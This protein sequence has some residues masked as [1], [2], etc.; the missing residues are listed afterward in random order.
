MDVRLRDRIDSCIDLSRSV[1]VLLDMRE[2]NLKKNREAQRN[3]LR[4]DSVVLA[5]VVAWL[6]K[7]IQVHRYI[8][9]C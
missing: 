5:L 1:S 3:L 4:R 6:L 9:S 8:G 7:N 2:N